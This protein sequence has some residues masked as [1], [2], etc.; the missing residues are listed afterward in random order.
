MRFVHLPYS[1]GGNPGQ[2]SRALR[3]LGF[4]SETW[5]LEHDWL[6]YPVDKVFVAGNSNSKLLRA[7]KLEFAKFSMVRYLF[8]FDVAVFS[9]G[10]SVFCPRRSGFRGGLPAVPFWIAYNLC[11]AVMQL[12]ELSTLRLLGR[13]IVVVFQ[14]DDARQGRF[15]ARNFDISFVADVPPGYYSRLGDLVKRYQAR[16][17]DLFANHIYY[18]NPDLS[19]V[20][21]RR[22]TFLPYALELSIKSADRSGHESHDVFVV[23]HAPTSRAVKGTDDVI[24]AV[25]ALNSRGVE[26]ELL[27]VENLEHSEALRKYQQAD[28]F[29]DQLR[30]GW[31]GALAV[32][33]MALGKPVISYLREEDFHVL[34][35]GMRE[36]LPVISSQASNLQEVLERVV[37]FSVEERDAIGA[38]SKQYARTWHSPVVVARAVLQD[39]GLKLPSAE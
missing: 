32:E 15:A 26:C 16:V 34:P 29:V 35:A 17:W 8:L 39:L 22:A 10:S 24:R 11:Q 20:L 6:K 7:V 30:A 5:V 18:L 1:T 13:R 31:Y 37:R 28:I 25:D 2:L 19:Y 3:R 27:L 38:Q 21:P 12:V 33:V 4:E 9:F 23:G 36:A 14:G